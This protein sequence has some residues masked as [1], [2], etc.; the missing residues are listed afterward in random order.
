ML[1]NLFRLISPRL[2]F[3]LI[4]YFVISIGYAFYSQIYNG[5]QPL[6]TVH[7]STYYLWVLGLFSLIA[8]INNCKGFGNRIYGILLAIALFGVKTAYRIVWLQSPPPDQWPALRYAFRH[9]V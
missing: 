1:T 3:A 7:C 6:P 2:T 4:L 9:F 8:L 5:A